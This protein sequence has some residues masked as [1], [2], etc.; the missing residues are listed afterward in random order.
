MNSIPVKIVRWILRITS[1]LFAVGVLIFIFGDVMDSGIAL[2]S[3]RTFFVLMLIGICLAGLG[4][5]WKW[6]IA[7]GLVALIAYLILA[8][9]WSEVILGRTYYFFILIPL[10]SVL[11]ILLGAL[12]RNKNAKLE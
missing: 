10:S 2:M 11:F 1:A 6:E 9:I 3:T 12:S 4:L 7:G 5:S 8:I